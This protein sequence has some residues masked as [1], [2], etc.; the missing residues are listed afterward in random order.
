MLAAN[1]VIFNGCVCV[2]NEDC[3]DVSLVVVLVMEILTLI[4]VE[5]VMKKM[6]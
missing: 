5:V 1:V 3:D 2:N 6:I 4:L